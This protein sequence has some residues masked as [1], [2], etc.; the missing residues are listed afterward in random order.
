MKKII[1]IPVLVFIQFIAQAQHVRVKLD[2][3]AGSTRYAVGNPPYRG[4]CWVEPDWKWQ[5]GRYVFVPGHW[6]KPRGRHH[7][8]VSGHWRHSRRGYVWSP[9]HWK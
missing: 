7:R 5:Q 6:D 2:F 1:F 3:P 9:G 8:W 4:A